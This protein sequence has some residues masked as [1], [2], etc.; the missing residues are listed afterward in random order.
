MVCF[1]LFFAT[2]DLRCTVEIVPQDC[3]LVISTV[4]PAFRHRVFELYRP[5]A[6]RKKRQQFE[7][8][9]D[10]EN[11]QMTKCDDGHVV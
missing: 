1:C 4:Y 7:Q 6:L 8:R 2:L 10:K 9:Q 3:I 5:A 11:L